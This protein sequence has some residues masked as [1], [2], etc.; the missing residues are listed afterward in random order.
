MVF[1]SFCIS[2]AVFKVFV[3]HNLFHLWAN[4]L[5]LSSP[6]IQNLGS[7]S[8]VDLGSHKHTNVSSNIVDVASLLKLGLMPPQLTP[9]NATTTSTITPS[10]HYRHTAL[11]GGGDSVVWVMIFGGGMDGFGGILSG[12]GG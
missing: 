5:E 12:S 10:L 11:L 8:V 1:C 7:L 3:S 6:P 2:A 9:L 4:A